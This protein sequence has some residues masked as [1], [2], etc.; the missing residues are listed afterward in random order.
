MTDTAA[1]PAG[2]QDAPDAVH[3]TVDGRSVDALPGELLIE[4][5]ERAGVYIPR[6][7]YHPRMEPVGMCRMCLVEVSG[8][9]GFSLQPACYLRVA[10]G[11]EI[12]T[13]SPKARKAQEG[14]LEFLLVNHPLDCPVCDK[15]GEC[16]LQD[17]A[18]SHGPGESRFIEEKRHWAKPI[19][20]GPLVFLDR[21]RCIQCARCTRFAD[22]VAGEALID[23][24]FRG[25]TIEVAPFPEQPFTSYF[26]GNTVQICPVGALTA[27]PYRFKSRPWDLEQ[28]ETTCTTCSVG[29][30]VVAQSSA[31][32]LVRYLGVDSDPVNRSWLCDKG[33]YGFEAVNASTR[34]VD[35]L[36][37]RAGSLAVVRWH[38]AIGEVAAGA[39]QALA[40][41]NADAIG[42]IGG[43]RLANEDGYAWAKLARTVLATDS[44][45]AQLGDGL[46]AEVVLGLPRATIDEAASAKVLVLITGD[47]REEL[48]VLFLRLREAAKRGTAIIECSPVASALSSLAAVRLAHR[49]GEAAQLAAALVATGDPGETAGVAV[50]DLETARRLIGGA[51]GEG[52]ERGAGVVAVVG[53]PS[54]S[55]SSAAVASAVSILHAALPGARFLPSLRRANVHGALDMGLA[56]GVLP[57]RVSLEAGRS[58][59]AESW[60]SD[61]PVARGRD[62]AGI[63]AAAAAG[64][65]KML[66]LLG[67]D[68]LAD[69]PDRQ[70]AAAA[71]ETVPFLVSLGTHPDASSQIAHVV[72]PVAG[73]G[74]RSGTTTN[75]EGRVSRLAPKVVAPGVAWPSWMVAAELARRLGGDLGFENIEAISE[76]IERLAPAYR[77]VTGDVLARPSGRDGLVVPVVAVAVSIGRRAA[78]RPID[79]MATPGITSVEEQGAPLRV[80]ATVPLG[81][82]AERDLSLPEPS[83]SRPPLIAGPP[84]AEIVNVSRLDAYSHRLV[85]RRRL[86]DGGTL[87][88]A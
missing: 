3:V 87:V 48:P 85:V 78:E 39:R 7:C 28:V 74:E 41:G 62:C 57:G 43:A 59:Y 68:P 44:V 32:T 84:P 66:V 50:A 83:A 76:E 72:L 30:R 13:A 14:V 20:I 12:V 79:P 4:A 8:P 27:P 55:E 10:E 64:E 24:A 46:P 75:L 53:R 18:L 61:L 60:G 9:R 52:A 11:Q 35:P 56:P 36:V 37:R 25:A 33:R 2:P 77:G 70:L 23:F 1:R 81:G 73:D 51:H 49:P 38:D 6:F 65:L 58:W 47:L 29:C 5:A 82:E 45:D 86:Y 21:E 69:F 22:E 15:G 16:P 19:E 17:Q 31:G 26:S 88:A 54:L 67:A 63:L 80:G 71:L 42:I 34:L 40:S